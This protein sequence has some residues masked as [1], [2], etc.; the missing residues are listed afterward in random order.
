[1]STYTKW[2]EEASTSL[3]LFLT[4]ICRKTLKIGSV[5]LN[6]HA[7]EWAHSYL[8]VWGIFRP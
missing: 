8:T 7:V 2:R 4:Y 6:S 1:M 5:K 3:S